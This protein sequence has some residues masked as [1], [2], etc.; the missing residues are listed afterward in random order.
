MIQNGA[1]REQKKNGKPES[2][3]PV[4]CIQ[5]CAALL[6]RFRSARTPIM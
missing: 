2:L 3:P 1:A 5:F 4:V 6:R